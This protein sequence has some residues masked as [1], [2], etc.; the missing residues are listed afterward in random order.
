M[1]SCEDARES[2]IV[3]DVE[4]L[5][6]ELHELSQRTKPSPDERPERREQALLVIGK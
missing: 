2:V 4:R 1:R 5:R 3:A 6:Q